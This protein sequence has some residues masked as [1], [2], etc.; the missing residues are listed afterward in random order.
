MSQLARIAR[1]VRHPVKGLPGHGIPLARLTAL[2]GVPRDR[3]FAFARRPVP[4][5]GTWASTRHFHAL[6]AAP[7]PA[8]GRVRIDEEAGTATLT[9]P[10]YESVTVP[11]DPHAPGLVARTDWFGGAELHRAEHGYWDDKATVSLLNL[12]SVEALSDA[13]GHAVDPRRFRANLWLAHLPAWAEL[14]LP[15]ARIAVGGARLEVLH[16]V[17]RCAAT[18]VDPG[19]ARR[20]LNVPAELATRFGHLYCGLRARVVEPGTVREDDPVVLLAPGRPVPLHGGPQPAAWPRRARVEERVR[21]GDGAVSLWLADPL[22]EERPAPRHGQHVLVTAHTA[23]GPLWRAYTVSAHDAGRLRITVKHEPEGRMSPHLHRH[24]HPGTL[25]TVSGP[26]GRTVLDDDAARPLLLASAGI[27]VTQTAALLHGCAAEQPDRRVEVVHTARGPEDL[28]LWPEILDLATRLP[29]ARAR[30]HLTRA[31]A[32][33]A[34][35]LDAVRG[36]PVLDDADPASTAF[37][38]GPA[39]FLAT[40]RK[41]LRAAGLADA[42]VHEEVFASPGASGTAP[43]ETPEGPFTVRFAASGRTAKWRP[44][45]GTLAEL[46]ESEG[47]TVPSGCRAGACRSCSKPL[48]DGRVVYPLPPTLPPDRGTA[49]LC[50]AVPASDTVIDL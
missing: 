44:E 31:T 33:D 11:L 7:G 30:L 28:A 21:H 12:A 41:A 24:A 15:G 18:S 25:L 19:R 1:I 40:A 49:L 37:L 29:H 38:C 17:N 43:E 39:S 6:V 8:D 47:L 34:E 26:H 14:D 3:L 48:C 5:G 42:R 32:R 27:G 22:A 4:A 2:G 50:S 46:A 10:T 36:R 9:H 20:D 35:R 45:S 16:P 13:C 23:A